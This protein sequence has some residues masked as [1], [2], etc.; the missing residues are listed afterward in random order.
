MLFKSLGTMWRFAKLPTKQ[1]TMKRFVSYR[2]NCKFFNKPRCDASALHQT[3]CYKDIK[4]GRVLPD[5]PLQDLWYKKECCDD[6][7]QDAYVRFDDL[8]YFVSDKKERKYTRTWRECPK[9][10]R[11][12]KRVCCFDGKERAPPLP[13]RP[14]DAVIDTACPADPNCMALTGNCPKIASQGCRPARKIPSCRKEKR[15]AD[16]YKFCTPFPSFSEC[17][18]DQPPRRHPIECPCLN[19]PMNCELR[20]VKLPPKLPRC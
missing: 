10:L 16:C 1:D 15:P 17:Q 12:C 11:V 6:P 18:R 7:C 20:G 19:L 3:E 13:K 5:H 14:K 9:T 2:K 4:A 8:Y